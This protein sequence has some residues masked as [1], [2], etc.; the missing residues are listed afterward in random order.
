M[1]ADAVVQE[2]EVELKSG[3]SCQV[4]DNE[5]SSEDNLMINIW[6]RMSGDDWWLPNRP[7]SKPPVIPVW[8]K[9][10]NLALL[11]CQDKMES[12]NFNEIW[13]FSLEDNFNGYFGVAS[14]QNIDNA[15]K[16]RL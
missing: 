4:A 7:S 2:V 15:N 5:N 1:K 10:L 8:L 6:A 12:Q 3:F 16:I 14:K 11:L 13:N 9:K